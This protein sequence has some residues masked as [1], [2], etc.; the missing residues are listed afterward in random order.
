MA[1]LTKPPFWWPNKDVVKYHIFINFVSVALA[2]LTIYLMLTNQP[3][4]SNPWVVPETIMLAILTY[5]YVWHL[6]NVKD[7]K[8][9]FIWHI[10]DLLSLIPISGLASLRLIRIVSLLSKTAN[11]YLVKTR[12]LYVYYL[13]FM[14]VIVS[15]EVFSLVEN[16]TFAEAIY[17][18]ITTFSTSGYGDIVPTHHL[19]RIL[20][21]ILMLLGISM[22][23][24]IASSIGRLVTYDPT[25]ELMDKISALQRKLDKVEN[26]K[27]EQNKKD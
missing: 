1:K 16:T 6:I 24:V 26:M 10:F 11:R 5:D 19:T 15:A 12:L 22:I 13:I 4:L 7:K 3:S 17:W 23:G 27:K 8:R 25:D 2:I 18:A 9:W 14:M 20:S 21:M